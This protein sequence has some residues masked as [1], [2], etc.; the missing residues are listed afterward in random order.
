MNLSK[1][2]ERQLIGLAVF[3]VLFFIVSYMN[4]NDQ[5]KVTQ[6]LKTYLQSPQ[7]IDDFKQAANPKI[8]A[9]VNYPQINFYITFEYY[10]R[11]RS[12]SSEE[13][14]SAEHRKCD[15]IL[16]LFEKLNADKPKKK[17]ILNALAEE[18]IAIKNMYRNKYAE[19]MY[20]T[21]ITLK[22]CE[23]WYPKK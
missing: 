21:E 16:N 12:Y 5:D 9:L 15:F 19:T 20:S 3:T 10:D 11:S 18:N 6:E 7:F 17:K 2:L 13:M 23:N 22:N 8:E 1:K 14:L 4:G